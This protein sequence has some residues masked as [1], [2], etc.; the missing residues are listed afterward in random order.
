MFQE[1][2]SFA[3]ESCCLQINFSLDFMVMKNQAAMA[4][5]A[6][7][8]TGWGDYRPWKHLVLG[9][10]LLVILMGRVPLLWMSGEFVAEDGR[11][12]FAD[13]WNEPLYRSILFPYAGYFHLLP[14]LIV[15]SL[16][17][18]PI[19]WQPYA[20]A[21]IGLS[22]NAMTCS[23]FYLPHFR[24]ALPPDTW[25]IALAL[26][27]ALAPNGEN[28]GLLLGLHW[29]LAFALG[30]T[31]IMDPP[32][33]GMGRLS[34]SVMAILSVWSS[35]STLALI[36]CFL[37]RAFSTSKQAVRRWCF[38][39]L[40][41]QIVVGGFILYFQLQNPERTDNF[42]LLD[43]VSASDRL[44]LRGWI[45]SG[46]L[47]SRLSHILAEQAPLLL[48]AFGI[49][50]IASILIA[51]IRN[52]G[53][54]MAGNAS[55]LLGSAVF[56]ILLSMTRTLYLGEMG[57]LN[58]PRHTRY[59]TAP[60]LLL[61]AGLGVLLYPFIRHWRP[62]HAFA[63]FTLHAAL[64]VWGHPIETHW[65]RPPG[66]FTLQEAIPAIQ[67]FREQHQKTGEPASLYIPN[68]IPYD[69]PVLHLG[70]GVIHLPREGLAHAIGA[71]PGEEPNAWDSWLG[72]FVETP[73]S[74]WIEHRAWGRLKYLGI[75]GGRV[76]FQDERERLLF[77]SPLL[78]PRIWIIDGTDIRLL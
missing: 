26:L 4:E 10:I 14:R 74:N 69:G 11:I 1:E 16:S 57:E 47:G 22:L 19:P 62:R 75:W 55:L 58:L 54:S 38:L 77:T 29:Y 32:R 51:L 61:I 41:N 44:F 23:L 60:T 5:Y 76:W 73:K 30:L 17:V 12:F 71:V 27:L 64:L 18:L 40:S 42:Q 13:A 65:S 7:G 15:E 56:M 49:L 37:Y 33:S 24:T 63:L 31:L 28:L 25:R 2:P 78:Y 50:T 39:V 53:V 48:Q 46:L 52:R 20:Y 43:L 9:I 67:A 59:L 3:T 8:Q 68:D 45:G 66:R 35:P 34:A 36:P 6:A 70:G 72:R 21:L